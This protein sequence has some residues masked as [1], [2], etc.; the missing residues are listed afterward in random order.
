M[1]R[2]KR[3]RK[4][5]QPTLPARGATLYLQ[6]PSKRAIDFNPRS[7]HGERQLRRMCRVHPANFNPR[8]PHGERLVGIVAAFAS[9][10][11]QPT[12]PARGATH[13]PRLLFPFFDISTHAPRT[14]SDDSDVWISCATCQFQPTLP[15]RGATIR[16]PRLSRHTRH[17]NPRSPHGERQDACFACAHSIRI[18]THAPRTGSDRML[19]LLAL[20]ASAFQPTLPARG[21]TCF[22]P[23]WTALT[24]IS[25]H[26]PRTGS[27]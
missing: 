15:A 4:I 3:Q 27:D 18:S 14:G 1:R 25:T 8:S 17:F 23:A 13:E 2:W 22:V 19:V 20:T 6:T 5:F 26:A 11:F 16:H 12:L 10:R 21:A 7:P 9:A 24:F